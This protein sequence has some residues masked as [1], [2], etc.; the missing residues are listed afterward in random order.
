MLTRGG[1]R[2]G[3]HFADGFRSVADGVSIPHDVAEGFIVSPG[4]G[5]GSPSNHLV[6]LHFG[7]QG[8]V[9]G[10]DCSCVLGVARLVGVM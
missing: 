5:V 3:T 2:L 7:L 6:H 4:P 10:E 8:V 1:S 9:P